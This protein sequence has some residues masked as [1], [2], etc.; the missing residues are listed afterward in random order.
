MCNVW[1][2]IG[3]GRQQK[4]VFADNAAVVS[5]AMNESLSTCNE[6]WVSA[7]QEVPGPA[8]LPLWFS[9]PEKSS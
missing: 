9:L 2:A 3:S 7:M 4:Q 5:I 6:F 1:V 8:A